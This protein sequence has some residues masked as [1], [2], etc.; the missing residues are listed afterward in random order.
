MT[1]E[2]NRPIPNSYWVIPGQLVAGEY[3][4]ALNDLDAAN[5][6]RALLKAGI[7]HFIDM[8]ESGELEPYAEIAQEQ[9]RRLGLTV[10]HERH[11]IIDLSV[12]RSPQ[13]M[14]T[15]LDAIDGA[16]GDGKTVYVHCWGGVG[17]TGTVI[18]CWLVR[19][20]HTG[21]G[22]LRKIAEW[23]QG[24]AKICWHPRSPETPEQHEYVRNWTETG[25]QR[26][27]VAC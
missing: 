27:S 20:G 4:G 22:A 21:D 10:G 19:Q 12:P 23:W 14:S 3:P 11:P 25:T 1:D 16:M 9:A 15:T 8:T 24:V 26:A 13:Q 5:K 17:R 18:G 6:V 7:N 2:E